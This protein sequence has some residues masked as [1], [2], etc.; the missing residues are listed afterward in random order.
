MPSR[1][2]PTS[3]LPFDDSTTGLDWQPSK[4]SHK[5]NRHTAA[6]PRGSPCRVAGCTGET[7]SASW[8]PWCNRHA[9][10]ARRYGH[11]QQ[12]MVKVGELAPYL[13]VVKRIRERQLLS[14]RNSAMDWSAV[15]AR[16]QA[17][18]AVARDVV[19][20][21]RIGRADFGHRRQAAELV[22]QI[23][24]NV[25]DA[26]AVDIVIALYLMAEFDAPRFRSDEG[27]RACLLHY[28]RREAKV[29]RRFDLKS[30]ADREKASYKILGRKVR[31]EA[32]RWVNEGLGAVGVH[33]AN[34][35]RQR[36][37]QQEAGRAAFNAALDA[38]V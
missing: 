29:G 7:K 34:K 37:R 2:S 10:L 9:M 20:Q 33:I 18:V 6:R 12:T 19:A 26:R 25:S 5:A 23:A 24:D 11:P 1:L 32:A 28:L 38:I 22:T 13:K 4:P 31:E 35:E 14:E 21:A 27:F 36:V 17:V 30:A 8:G 15:Y 3:A 16:W